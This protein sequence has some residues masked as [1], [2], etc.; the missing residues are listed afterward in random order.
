V[1]GHAELDTLAQAQHG[2]VSHRQ[3]IE[4][5]GSWGFRRAVAQ[6]QLT[7][8][9]RGV[10]RCA[11]TTST[12]RQRAMAA[13]LA[14]GPPVAVSH[15]SAAVL[16][17]YEPVAAGR[18]IEVS[19]PRARSGRRS[20]VRAHRVALDDTDLDRRYGI[21]VTCPGRTL[22]DLAGVMPAAVLER[23]IDDAIRAR[24]STAVELRRWLEQSGRHGFD[25]AGRLSRLLERRAAT[26]VG[27]SAGVDRLHRL[28]VRSG[29]S[30]PVLGW[31]VV[32]A[33]RQRILDLAYPAEKI[34]IE[35]N[36][37][38]YHQMRSRMDDDHARTT[39][40]ELAGWLVIVVTAAH[41][42]ADTVDR[43]SRA[44]S[45]RAQEGRPWGGQNPGFA[46]PDS[47]SRGT[48]SV[49]PRRRG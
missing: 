12:F 49:S 27:D 24:Q 17:G 6:H 31:A 38:E 28:I 15:R 32:V 8:V 19:L 45:L 7:S 4:I 21:T 26:G 46:P 5:L 14:F 30:V 41:R 25:G 23:C 2:L 13:C 34:A 18:D 42:D 29:L 40:L 9:Q 48:A 16:W 47:D 22:L 39:E 20:G 43:I 33:G 1:K 44:L 3:A 35:F 36:G 11:G 10:F 37:W